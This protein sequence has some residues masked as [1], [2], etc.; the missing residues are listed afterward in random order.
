VKVPGLPEVPGLRSLTLFGSCC[1]E[2]TRSADSIPDWL[3]V[4]DD[5]DGVLRALGHGPFARAVARALPPPATV[6]PKLNLIEPGQLSWE[7]AARRDLYLAGRLSKRT[8]PVFV[9]DLEAGLELE[10]AGRAARATIA[11]VAQWGLPRVA[12]L[13]GV[14]RRC[15]SL[16]Y[17]AEVRPER[18]EK[19][20]ALHDAFAD[21]YRETYGP[22][23]AERVRGEVVVDERPEAERAGERRA[24]RRLLFRSRLRA[25]ARWPKGL[26]LYDGALTYLWAKLRRARAL[27]A[28]APSLDRAPKRAPASTG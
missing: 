24:L 21:W 17:E 15:V 9:R 5:V 11:E 12:P 10:A 25:V 14:I 13:A 1:S 23:L 16:S 22:L 6:A 18:P 28:G 3:A 26:V 2:L 19:I 27:P 4:V 8:Q 20:V 7:L